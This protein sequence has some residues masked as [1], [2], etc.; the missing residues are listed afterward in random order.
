MT[1]YAILTD[2]SPNRA[3]ASHVTANPADVADH[4]D[5][6]GDNHELAIVPWATCDGERVILSQCE[7]IEDVGAFVAA[8]A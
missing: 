3:T 4:V 7:V 2:I 6:L 1:T 5:D 8:L